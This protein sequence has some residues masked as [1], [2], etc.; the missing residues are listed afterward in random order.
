M[1]LDYFQQD[2]VMSAKNIFTAGVNALKQ[3]PTLK[4]IVI[5]IQ[6]M[7]ILCNSSLLYHSSLMELS[8][9]SG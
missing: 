8:W 3:Q 9:N 5:T 6:K 4:K 1:Y 7:L 2:T